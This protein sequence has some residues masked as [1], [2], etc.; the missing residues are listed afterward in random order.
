[1]NAQK[2]FTLIELMI[3]V[4]IIGILAAIAIPAYQDYIGRSQVAEGPALLGGL[5]TPITE[6]IGNDG[7]TAGCKIEDADGVVT[8]GQY[9]ASIT[10]TAGNDTCALEAKFKSSDINDNV[11]DQTITYTYTASTG[12]W[13]C[14]TS[15]ATKFAPKSCSA[16]APATGG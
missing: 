12:A 13:A 9:V 8:S 4:A 5:K 7:V 14:T 3:V 1:M 11:K 15:L 10:P 2:G 6:K 16:A